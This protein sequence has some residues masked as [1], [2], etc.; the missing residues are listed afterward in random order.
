MDLFIIITISAAAILLGRALLHRWFN[1]ITLYVVVWSMSLMLFQF[2]L[3]NYYPL[4]AETWIVIVDGFLA[5]IF[6]TITVFFARFACQHQGRLLP[7][8][9][10]EQYSALEIKILPRVIWVLSIISLLAVLQ[11]WYVLIGMFGSVQKVVVMGSI[12][13]AMRVKNAIAG[14]VPYLGALAPPAML[15][16]G[17]YAAIS[18]KF[19][20]VVVI[21]IVTVVIGA[22][23]D[24]GRANMLISG[25]LFFSGYMLSKRKPQSVLPGTASGKAQKFL[26]L[27]VGAVL[28]I[29]TAELVRS[30]RGMIE[31][32]EGAS[33]ALQRLHAASFITPS[34]YEYFTVH[35]GVLNQYLKLDQEH[36]GWG[37]NTFGPAYRI[38]SKFGFDTYT[39]DYMLFYRTPIGANT[40]TYLR[41]LH[42]DFGV[43]G[44]LIVPYLLGLLGAWVWY[45]YLDNPSYL[46]I[47]LISH[48]F[49]VIAFSLLMQATRLGYWWIS[50]FAASIPA[51]YLDWRLLRASKS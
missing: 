13:Y 20:P 36:T 41:E 8:H 16:A 25:I 30:N 27:L 19:R 22:I 1:Q 23:S 9:R 32:I 46:K 44:I 33:P 48:F 26:T 11:H 10:N 34:V 15:F 35:H 24:M 12:L 45:R 51:C 38:L 39:S 47:V 14:T 7:A 3:L 42:A 28:I 17:R 18:G 29:G 50:L 5:F 40:G 4:E 6:G 2:R 21:P 43:I 37:E 49:I 31:S